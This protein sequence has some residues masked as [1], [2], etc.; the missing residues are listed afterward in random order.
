MRG[1]SWQYDLL[2]HVGPALVL[3]LEGKIGGADRIEPLA[4]G[5][6]A[7]DRDPAV[8]VRRDAPAGIADAGIRQPVM[9]GRAGP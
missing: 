8:P 3:A 4:I 7:L 5:G 1:G 6:E 9:E 2:H